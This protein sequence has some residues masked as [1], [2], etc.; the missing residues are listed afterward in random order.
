MEENI[1]KLDKFGKFLMENFRDKAIF[2]A[3]NLLAG[4]WKASSLLELQS[5][6]AKFSEEEKEIIFFCVI[7]SLD[8][9][10]HDFLFALQDHNPNQS[11][12][13]KITVDDIN[14]EPL[15]QGLHGEI[16]SEEG[17]RARF[18][19]YGERNSI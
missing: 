19:N 8:N 3:E 1:D 6:L 15:S 13:V 16:F 17:W 11:A 5:K 18:S 14:I 2:Y 10:I 7:Q 9:G 4:K 12:E